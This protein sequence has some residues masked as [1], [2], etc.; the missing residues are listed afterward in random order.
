MFSYYTENKLHKNLNY[1]R[2]TWSSLLNKYKCS[3]LISNVYLN[4]IVKTISIDVQISFPPRAC[5]SHVQGL[6]CHAAY[7]A[8][9]CSQMAGC[10]NCEWLV[11]PGHTLTALAWWWCPGRLCSVC[12][13]QWQDSP[14]DTATNERREK[15]FVFSYARLLLLITWYLTFPMKSA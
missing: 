10:L 8:Q 15:F 9:V 11:W 2:K 1:C 3:F 6:Q 14:G 7:T 13:N 4:L 12:S 5:L